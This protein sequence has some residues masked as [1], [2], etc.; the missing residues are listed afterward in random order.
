MDNSHNNDGI[1]NLIS[2][3]ISSTDKI[4]KPDFSQKTGRELLGFYLQ[5]KFKQVLA[6]DKHS[7]VP[8]FISVKP[9]FI[10][11]FSK[12]LIN[13]PEKR[14]LVGITGESASGKS[15]ICNEISNI[16]KKLALPVSIL[17][18]DN[19]FNDISGLI[20]KYGS[21]DALRDNGYDID[22]PSS[23]QLDTLKKDLDALSQG[24]D[25]KIP[26]YLPN[27]TGVSIPQSIFIPSDKIIVVE[28]M[29][30]MYDE[31]KDVFDVTMYIET[32]IETRKE[33]FMKRA[34]EERNQDISNAQ[35][36]W[37]Y[38]LSAGEKYIVPSRA[39]VD[40]IL[41]GGCC[42]G[43]FVQILEYIYTITNNFEQ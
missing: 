37:E 9:D 43:Y 14:I 20:K 27:G 18:T 31:I 36:H 25:V 7:E 38:I 3:E 12:R 19:Y 24:Q 29:A 15:T 35:R 40:I 42:L 39:E 5:T 30:S 21:F 34:V 26:E 22:S 1:S 13:N 8:A 10:S 4:F 2:K 32:D 6:Y 16:I 17:T 28:G 11:R 33:R 41:N 23:F